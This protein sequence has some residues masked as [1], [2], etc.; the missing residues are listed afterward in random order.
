MTTETET[1]PKFDK[2]HW[3]SLA[4]SSQNA[5]NAGG[6]LRSASACAD[7]WRKAY[8]RSDQSGNIPL[9]FMLHQVAFLCGGLGLARYNDA[10]SEYA[11][12]DETL[13]VWVEEGEKEG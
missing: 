2:A 1:L 11:E 13:K 7:A 9:L 6:V 12:D 4:R 8:Q 5:S 3:A 10:F